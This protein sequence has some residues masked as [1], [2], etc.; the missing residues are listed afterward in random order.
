[1]SRN[2]IGCRGMYRTLSRL[3]RVL[4]GGRR[5]R[6]GWRVSRG[7]VCPSMCPGEGPP[8]ISGPAHRRGRAYCLRCRSPGVSRRPL[9]CR[10]RHSVRRG[11]HIRKRVPKAYAGCWR[12]SDYVLHENIINKSRINRIKEMGS[13]AVDTAA[14]L[15]AWRANHF[16]YSP[17]ILRGRLW[18]ER[19]RYYSLLLCLSESRKTMIFSCRCWRTASISSLRA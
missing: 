9:D 16:H 11:S 8:A 12:E 19:S 13:E 10:V 5:G 1:M 4:R 3:P 18:S 6:A 7:P 17:P 2:A 14:K 15:V